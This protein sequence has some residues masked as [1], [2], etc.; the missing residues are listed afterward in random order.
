MNILQSADVAPTANQ[1]AA[2][3]AAREGAATTM[4]RWNALKSELP[5]INAL[6]E[7]AGLE[8]ISVSRGS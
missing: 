6:L 2:I 8:R 7:G 4:A 5:A 3:A 1:R